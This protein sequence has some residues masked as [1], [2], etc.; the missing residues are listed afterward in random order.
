MS[1]NWFN[2]QNED[3]L[4]K[5]EIVNMTCDNYSGYSNSFIHA[6]SGSEVM[7]YNSSFS[8]MYSYAVGAVVRTETS[9]AL[10]EAFDTYFIENSALEAGAISVETESTFKCTD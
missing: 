7:I 3:M 4:T 10:V 9:S 8:G 1:F 2:S 6:Q 5:V